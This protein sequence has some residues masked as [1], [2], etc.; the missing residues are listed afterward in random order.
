[1]PSSSAKNV[2]ES[3]KPAGKSEGVTFVKMENGK[4]VYELGSGSY[5]F[6]AGK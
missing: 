3:G 5:L 4:A 6:V 1:V 2:T